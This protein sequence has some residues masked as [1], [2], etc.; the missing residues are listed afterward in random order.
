MK[1]FQHIRFR[2]VALR[3]IKEVVVTDNVGAH[4]LKELLNSEYPLENEVILAS[5]DVLISPGI[6]LM[7]SL[8]L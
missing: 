4:F 2:R 3:A 6:L 1:V 8:S 7:V 5:S